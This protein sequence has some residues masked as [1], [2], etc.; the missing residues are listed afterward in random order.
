MKKVLVT[1]GSGFI[2][3]AIC[4]ML[5]KKGISVTS[6][7]NNFR[8]NIKKKK[9]SIKYIKGDITKLEDLRKIRKNFDC[10]FHLAFINGTKFFYHQKYYILVHGNTSL[11]TTSTRAATAGAR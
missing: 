6:F 2:G 10:I 9:L 3:S 1:G 8:Q 11:G 4:K 7:D 5:T